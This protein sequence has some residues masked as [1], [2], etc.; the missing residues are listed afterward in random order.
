[1]T[2][3]AGLHRSLVDLSLVSQ[4][5]SVSSAPISPSI[6]EE[7]A[8]D[9]LLPIPLQVAQTPP[10]IPILLPLA[11]SVQLPRVSLDVLPLPIP[12]DVLAEL[13]AVAPSVQFIFR[14]QARQSVSRNK[15]RGNLTRLTRL[16]C[17]SDLLLD[18]GTC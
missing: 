2:G 6:T 7:A 4:P 8:G 17:L 16:D 9:P 13:P 12:L 3:G 11:D 1:M 5:P 14:V 10:V 15:V 18:E